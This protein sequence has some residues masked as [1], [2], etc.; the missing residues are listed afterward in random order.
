MFTTG[1]I[2]KLYP[3]LPTGIGLAIKQAW[4]TIDNDRMGKVSG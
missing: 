2:V 4:F 1:T 3:L